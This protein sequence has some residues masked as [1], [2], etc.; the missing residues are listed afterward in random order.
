MIRA[1][2]EGGSPTDQEFV[3]VA[4]GEAVRWVS[5][6]I[7]GQGDVDFL[8]RLGPLPG[9]TVAETVPGYWWYQ[10]PD[11]AHLVAGPTYE[12]RTG[13]DANGADPDAVIDIDVA[14]LAASPN[15]ILDLMHEIVHAYSFNGGPGRPS[16]FEDHTEGGYFV[17]EFA[18][19]AF[20]GPVPLAP[21][22][23]H[24]AMPGDL[25]FPSDGALAGFTA[26]DIAILADTGVPLQPIWSAFA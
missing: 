16:V 6:V 23:H 13:I 15:A 26:V 25:M 1:T 18:M 12:A 10:P 20:G 7:G 2:I 19:E 5:Q 4:F 14:K 22:G 9:L 17:G 8:L 24:L 21:D 3:R 11:V